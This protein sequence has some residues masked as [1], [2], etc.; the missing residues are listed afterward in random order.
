M[1]AF[2]ESDSGGSKCYATHGLLPSFIDWR[3]P[4]T[5]KRPLSTMSA[6][7]FTHQ[8]DLLLP[9]DVYRV[10]WQE[11]NSK[12]DPVQYSRVILP[13]SALL[14]G[15]FFN[16]YIKTGNIL[17]L[18][19]GRPPID[20]VY[21]LSEGVLRLELSK[22]SYERAG[23]VGKP[24]RG[25]GRKHAKIR[26]GNGKHINLRFCQY[27]DVAT[28][29]EIN[30]RLPSMLHGKKGFERIV[31]AFKNVLTQPVTWLFC[32]LNESRK[33]DSTS[34]AI[35]RHHPVTKICTPEVVNAFEALVPDLRPPRRHENLSDLDFSIFA[36]ELHEW[37][38]LCNLES[39]RLHPN[40]QDQTDPYLSSR[41]L[42]KH[43]PSAWFAITAYGFG[44]VAMDDETSYTSMRLPRTPNS[45]APT[46]ATGSYEE[47]V[48]GSEQS[49]PDEYM[50]W[51]LAGAAA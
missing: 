8:V 38:G 42:R 51:Q 14:E 18:S 16:S 41:E 9:E 21:S 10:I 20:N 27:A 50:L 2:A 3:E 29:A 11:V 45:D 49:P 39:P 24:I 44:G 48:D 37:L 19:E 33:A 5:K 35:S 40:D 6:Q 34:N 17:M 12:L 32:D 26:Y 47:I 1:F 7:P 23:L 22:D 25:A 30:L 36:T 43:S 13:L 31:W 4:P 46:E 28:A 15:D